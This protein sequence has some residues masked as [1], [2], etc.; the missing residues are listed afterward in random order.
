MFTLLP[1]PYDKSA[2]EPHISART[3]EFHYGKHHQAYIDNLNK[4]VAGTAWEKESL[5]NIVKKSAGAPEQIGLFNNAAQ[6]YNHAF[7]WDCL[8]PAAKKM[9]P[10]PELLNL[11]N[12]FFG[13]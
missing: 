12:N 9:D 8:R 2:L 5:E 4:L 1:L 11:I 6:A 7:F 3:L 10:D 13:S